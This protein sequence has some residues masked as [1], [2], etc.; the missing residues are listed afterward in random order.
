[1]KVHLAPG[2]RLLF[3]SDG[4]TEAENQAEEQ[5]G[6]KRL[7]EHLRQGEPSTQSIV[8][9]VRR[10]ANGVCLRDDASVILIKA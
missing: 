9:D 5:Y 1:M 6:Q 2:S 3:Y 4:I 8:E 10:F 7:A